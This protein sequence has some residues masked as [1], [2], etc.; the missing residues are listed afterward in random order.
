MLRPSMT[1]KALGILL[2]MT[3]MVLSGCTRRMIDF[4]V[5]SSKNVDLGNN[6]AAIGTERVEGVDT[7]WW[8]T[9]IP[10]CQPNMK[11][12]VD[13]AIESAGPGYD[14]LIDGVLTNKWWHVG[15]TGK[16]SSIVEGTPVNSG[17]LHGGDDGDE[18]AV[19]PVLY[20]S[21]LGVS[22][23]AAIEEIGIQIIVEDHRAEEPQSQP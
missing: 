7:C 4:T 14:A 2:A 17:D 3:L 9:F 12:A 18:I 10:L 19:G 15:L 20:H 5:I 8:V 6:R 11:E 13:R 22:N 23:E 1:P 21:S 16:M